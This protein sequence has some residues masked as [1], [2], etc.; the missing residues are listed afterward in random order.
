MRL[1]SNA[2][3]LAFGRKYVWEVFAWSICVT[4]DLGECVLGRWLGNLRL[5]AVAGAFTKG[6]SPESLRQESVARELSFKRVR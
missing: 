6:L 4:F 2:L 3:E 1:G 5:R